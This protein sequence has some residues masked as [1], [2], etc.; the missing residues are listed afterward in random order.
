MEQEQKQI[1][2]EFLPLTLSIETLGGISTPLVKRGTPLPAKRRETYSTATDNQKSVE[3]RVM[4]GERPMAN[5]NIELGTFKFKDIPEALKGI[6]QIVVSFDVDK[7]CNVT[8]QA[9]ESIS[10]NT[11][12]VTLEE[13]KVSLTEEI[14]ERSLT[15]AKE[16][17]IEDK[18][19]M[20]LRK[21]DDKIRSEQEKGFKSPNASV[22]ESLVSELGIAIMNKDLSLISQKSKELENKLGTL[23]TTNGINSI[24]DSFFSP[25]TTQTT[26]SFFSTKPTRTTTTPLKKPAPSKKETTEPINSVANTTS[27]M[28]YIQSFIESIDPDLEQKRLGTWEALNKNIQ[29]GKVQASH[30]MREVLRLLLNKISPEEEIQNTAWYK[31]FATDTNITRAM[32]IRFAIAGNSN[33]ISESTFNLIKDISAIVDSVLKV[34]QKRNSQLRK[35]ECIL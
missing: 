20:L 11:L 15:E 6:P 25:R 23:L 13:N 21:A 33:E 32:K 34:I 30:S 35:R 22:L 12:K 17:Q 5:Q 2:F 10:K 31:K 16:N 7:Y 3:I 9:T 14:I 26:G 28:S 29:D 24:F 27:T 18:A 1:Q 8:V 19:R 4:F